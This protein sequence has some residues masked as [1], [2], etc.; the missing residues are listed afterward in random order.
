[1]HLC[2]QLESRLHSLQQC[3]DSSHPQWRENRLGRALLGRAQWYHEEP[4]CATVVPFKVRLLECP[5]GVLVAYYIICP[6]CAFCLYFFPCIVRP[7]L[8]MSSCFMP[9]ATAKMSFKII[10]QSYFSFRDIDLQ[11]IPM[12]GFY[13]WMCFRERSM[14]SWNCFVHFCIY[15]HF[16]RSSPEALRNSVTLLSSKPLCFSWNCLF[17]SLPPFLLS[18]FLC[19]FLPSLLHCLLLSLPFNLLTN[20]LITF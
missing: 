5:S 19:S 2:S 14:N 8:C 13:L 10:F 17:S 11:S 1:M 6:F 4:I 16:Q 9:K 12:L 20:L 15:M 7:S 18:S 3:D